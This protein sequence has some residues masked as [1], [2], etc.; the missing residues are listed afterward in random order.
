MCRLL[1]GWLEPPLAPSRDTT[2]PAAQRLDAGG[3]SGLGRALS[4]CAGPSNEGRSG[5]RPALDWPALGR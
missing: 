4:T 5:I 3:H 2:R 1:A